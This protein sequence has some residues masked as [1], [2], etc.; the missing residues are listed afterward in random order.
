MR[1]IKATGLIII[2][3]QKSGVKIFSWIWQKVSGEMIG[4]KNTTLTIQ[5]RSQFDIRLDFD[6]II[7][8]LIS[9]VQ[10][11]D[12]DPKLFSILTANYLSKP[13]LIK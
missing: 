10:N 3:S 8:K 2:D 4:N 7:L 6:I 13:I 1:V 9:L 5:F 11:S 12:T